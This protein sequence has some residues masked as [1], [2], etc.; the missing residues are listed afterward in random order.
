VTWGSD[1]EA[2]RRRGDPRARRARRGCGKTVLNTAKGEK[3]IADV[4]GL[5]GHDLLDQAP[6]RNDPGLLLAAADQPA[7]EDIPR[8]QRRDLADLIARLADHEPRLRLAA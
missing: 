6:E 8:G 3:R 5:C 4:V 7:A 2:C 1:A